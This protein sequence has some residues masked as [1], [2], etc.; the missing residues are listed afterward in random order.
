MTWGHPYKITLRPRHIPGCLNVIADLLSRS[1]QVQSSEA[2]LHPLVFKQ[3]CQKWFVPHVDL[4]ATPLNHKVPLYV[5]PVPDQHAWDIDALNIVWSGL[6]AYAYPP[7]ALLDRVIQIQA[8]PLPHCNN[9]RL[10][11]DALV[12]GPSVARNGDP[13]PVSNSPTTKCFTTMHSFSSF[14]PGV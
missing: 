9:P 2:S 5:S 14:T 13:T 6:T 3:I 4:F 7:T 10:A 12:Q 11:R 8:T 1:N